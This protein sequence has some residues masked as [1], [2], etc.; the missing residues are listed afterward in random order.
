[1]EKARAAALGQLPAVLVQQ[2]HLAFTQGQ[3][4]MTYLHSTPEQ[5]AA[6]GS[7]CPKETNLFRDRLKQLIGSAMQQV[8]PLAP[9]QQGVEKDRRR[10]MSQDPQLHWCAI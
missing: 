10:R 8:E 7:L 3:Q 6:T 9:N 5:Y 1:M 2:A 4:T